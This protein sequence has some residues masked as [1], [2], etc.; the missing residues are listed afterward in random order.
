MRVDIERLALRYGATTAI[1][2]LDLAIEPGELLAVIGPNGSGKSSLVKA[3]A[4]Q[5]RHEG[6][7]LFDGVAKRPERMGYMPQDTGSRAALT[8]LEAVLLGRLGR[9][10]L[11]VGPADLAAAEAV[12]AELDLAALASRYLGE[13]SGGQRQLAFLAQALAGDPRLLLLDE[14]ISAL[15]IRHQLE[16]MQT[17]RRLTDER[18]LTT[19][20]V[21]HDLNIAARFADRIAAMRQGRLV[22]IGD[23]ADVV[24]P[25]L[26]ADVF[27]VEAALS[28]APDG[29]PVITP[30][31]PL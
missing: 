2:S 22:R 10:G 31:R 4:G 3:I 8:V 11:R 27:G 7:I 9:L 20:V 12:I 14:P 26:V 23:P 24:A 16:V 17:V 29:C 1:A 25:G 19:L 30:V 13:L 6:R 28:C 15:D 21:L 18:G 5:A